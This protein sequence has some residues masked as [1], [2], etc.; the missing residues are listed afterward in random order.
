M[1][2]LCWAV[3]RGVADPHRRAL[4]LACRARA[5]ELAHDLGLPTEEIDYLVAGINHMAF[6]LRFEH[7]GED[8]YPR[9]ARASTPPDCNRVRYELLKHFGYFVTES[10]R[11][12]RRVRRRGSSRTAART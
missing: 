12:L 4:P 3:A 11:A 7:E 10:S 9:A 1:A 5:S 2:M 8:L 6:F